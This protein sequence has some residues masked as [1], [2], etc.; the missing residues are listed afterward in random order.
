MRLDAARSTLTARHVELLRRAVASAAFAP[1]L[2]VEVELAAASLSAATSGTTRAVLQLHVATGAASAAARL[3]RALH[4]QRLRR[5]CSRLGVRGLRPTLTMEPFVL[6]GSSA[7]VPAESDAA[8]AMSA[9][10]AVAA[11]PV[12]SRAAR[13]T[14]AAPRAAP[15]APAPPPLLRTGRGRASMPRSS[16][17]AL[18]EVE[19]HASAQ[20]RVHANLAALARASSAAVRLM[21]VHGAPRDDV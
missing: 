9:T 4:T 1:I 21:R 12:G 7:F 16:T 17:D 18:A 14:I 19:R 10:S 5:A 6:P 3:A 2:G 13:A 20:L 11:Q 8:H 15:V